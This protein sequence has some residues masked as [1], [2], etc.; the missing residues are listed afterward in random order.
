[1]RDYEIYRQQRAVVSLNTSPVDNP[2]LTIV[3]EFNENQ[4]DPNIESPAFALYNLEVTLDSGDSCDSYGMFCEIK[5]LTIFF[6]PY[7]HCLTYLEM[8]ENLAFTVEKVKGLSR[9]Y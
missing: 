7:K 3:G 5:S 1:M 9:D 2:Q 6:Q 4:I 8:Q